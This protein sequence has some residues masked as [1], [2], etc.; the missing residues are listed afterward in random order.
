MKEASSLQLGR[1][2]YTPPHPAPFTVHVDLL[3][4]VSVLLGRFGQLSQAA[5]GRSSSVQNYG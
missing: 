5:C 2:K 4:V 1:N 3:C